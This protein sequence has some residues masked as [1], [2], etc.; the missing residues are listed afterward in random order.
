MRTIY[1]LRT[2]SN[3]HHEI[4]EKKPGK[5]LTIHSTYDNSWEAEDA[6]DELRD[7]EKELHSKPSQAEL[8]DWLSDTFQKLK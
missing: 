8:I 5:P 2:V 7:K 3:D 1:S 6:L 4:L